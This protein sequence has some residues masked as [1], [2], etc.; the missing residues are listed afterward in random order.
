MTVPQSRE[1]SQVVVHA[2]SASRMSMT[3]SFEV[4]DRTLAEIAA[5]GKNRISH[6]SRALRALASLLRT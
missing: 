6:R 5:A 4:G 3:R 1:S 2:A